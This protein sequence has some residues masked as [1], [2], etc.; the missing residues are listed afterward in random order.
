MLSDVFC[1]KI[2][3]QETIPSSQTSINKWINLKDKQTYTLGSINNTV[4]PSE[5][6]FYKHNF[7]TL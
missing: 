5:N 6:A 2:T 4:E 3:F 1:L 7:E